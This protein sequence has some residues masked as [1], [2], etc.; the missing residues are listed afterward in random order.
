MCIEYSIFTDEHEWYVPNRNELIWLLY[1]FVYKQG[2]DVDDVK[3]EQGLS[4]IKAN[5]ARDVVKQIKPNIKDV[6]EFVVELNKLDVPKHLH[7][8]IPKS[9]K[10]QGKEKRDVFAASYARRQSYDATT[11]D[12]MKKP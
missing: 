3:I 7:P 11:Y 4:K 5:W 6:S 2:V 1:K 10:E 12:I 9:K 8:Y